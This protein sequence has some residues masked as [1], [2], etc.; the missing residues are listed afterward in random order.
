MSSF[1][2]KLYAMMGF[3]PKKE[4]GESAPKAARSDSFHAL[5]AQYSAC[6]DAQQKAAL[7]EKMLRALPGTLFLA[8]MCFEGEN[9]NASVCDKELHATVGA[10]RLYEANES[11]VTKGNPGYR[12]AK[13]ADD[14]RIQ[15]KTLVS[16]KSKEVWVPLFTDFNALLPIFGKDSRITIISFAEAR[17]MAKGHKGIMINPG[18]DV[19]VLDHNELKKTL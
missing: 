19:I 17:Q 7:W 18:K 1:M 6:E 13:K 9:P 4:S 10:K 12:L 14:R 5:S 2:D 16:N 8:A 11:A 3:K 15:L